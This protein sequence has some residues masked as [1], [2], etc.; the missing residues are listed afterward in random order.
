MS[1]VSAASWQAARM[2]S[3]MVGLMISMF[4]DTMKLQDRAVSGAKQPRDS[5]GRVR[6]REGG[7]QVDHDD[8]DAEEH[9]AGRKQPRSIPIRFFAGDALLF[10]FAHNG[11]RAG[12][13]IAP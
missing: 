13:L 10:G 5:P 9:Q 2:R 6:E 4:A 12:R 11:L 1:S 3:I 7:R 8:A